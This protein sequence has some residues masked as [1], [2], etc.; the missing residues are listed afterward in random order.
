MVN[1]PQIRGPIPFIQ[2][3]SSVPFEW[4]IG[5]ES[6]VDFCARTT[7]YPVICKRIAL[8]DL[9]N[10]SLNAME[11]AQSFYLDDSQLIWTKDRLSEATEIGVVPREGA[12]SR[13]CSKGS[14]R[15]CM[16]AWRAFYSVR[17]EVEYLGDHISI[18]CS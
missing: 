18:E 12:E 4:Q 2:F 7:C 8:K 9:K 6:V 5:S 11:A 3:K 1:R 16:T 15:P 13:F 17:F 10:T 14:T